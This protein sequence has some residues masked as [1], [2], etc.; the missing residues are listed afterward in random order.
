MDNTTPPQRPPS[1]PIK[2]SWE[3]LLEE[4]QGYARNFNDQAIPTYQRIVDG[5]L[6]LGHVGVAV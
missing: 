1:P 2:G 6:A 3:A 5:L 4:A